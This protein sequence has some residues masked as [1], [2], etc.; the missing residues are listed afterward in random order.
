[1]SPTH[2]VRLIR[3]EEANKL[4]QT[5]FLS[6]KEIMVAVGFAD[7]SHFVRD[8]K[9]QYGKTPLETRASGWKT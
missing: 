5:T 9:A 1:M 7:P 6:V 8:Y 2:L 4:L 3:L